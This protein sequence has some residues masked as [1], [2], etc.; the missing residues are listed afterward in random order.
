MASAAFRTLAG[1]LGVCEV[2]VRGEQHPLQC[3]FRTTM[4]E[5]MS[6]IV[7]AERV[8]RSAEK[9]IVEA[10][11]LGVAELPAGLQ[12]ESQTR[13]VEQSLADLVAEVSQT[14]S[15]DLAA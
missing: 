13:A 6:P 9:I 10:L 12:D 2:F 14:P 3:L 7:Q 8:G 1:S 15:I 5:K 4:G 11:Y